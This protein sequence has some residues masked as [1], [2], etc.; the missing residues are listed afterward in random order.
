LTNGAP[1]KFEQLW[2]TRGKVELDTKTQTGIITG[3]RNQIH[4][5]LAATDKTSVSLKSASIDSHCRERFIHVT[6]GAMGKVL[7]ASI[8]STQPINGKVEIHESDESVIVA[9]GDMKAH[10]TPSA[11]HLK[12]ARVEI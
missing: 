4:V 11:S 5:G 7:L 6:G 2:H 8:F 3:I 12:L 1:E 10:F 9:A